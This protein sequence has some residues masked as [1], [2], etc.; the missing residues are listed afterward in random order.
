[1]NGAAVFEFA[2]GTFGETGPAGP[3]WDCSIAGRHIRIIYAD[4]ALAAR[5]ASVITHLERVK[6]KA[7]SCPDLTIWAWDD[8]AANIET[9]EPT[10][11][12]DARGIV[13]HGGSI[14]FAYDILVRRMELYD[15]RSGLGLF[16]VPDARDLSARDQAA[17]FLRIFHVWSQAEGLQLVHGA[18][19]GT[20][21]G[22]VLLVGRSG[23]GKSTTALACVGGALRYL[24]DDSSLIEF[25]H[26]PHVHSLYSSGKADPRSITM[27]PG[28]VDDFEPI[29]NDNKSVIFL[30]RRYRSAILSSA[31]LRAIIIPQI[32]PDSDCEAAPAS[33]ETALRALA[34][35]TIFQMPGDRAQSFARM[36]TLVRRLP[37]WTLRLG[38]D[39][40]AA[41]PVLLNIITRSC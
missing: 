33:A 34:P 9:P 20:S 17:P 1:M 18:A 24:A 8:A 21:A 11:G 15:A 41:Q 16:R 27:L 19:V 40:R 6:P 32:V 13:Y 36:A 26:R 2:R 35:S 29:P 23:S 39:P 38:M 12:H 14:F 37:C 22:A 10:V 5:F 7:G 25:G 30:S 31:P 28:L 3:Q 4:A